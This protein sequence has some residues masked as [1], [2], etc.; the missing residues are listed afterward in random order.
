[1]EARFVDRPAFTVAGVAQSGQLGEFKY[2]EIWEKQYMPFDEQI[3]PF[4]IDGGYYG[5][6]LG[7]G[8]HLVYL[9]GMAVE[10]LQ[11]LPQGVERRVIPAA[12]YAVFDCS[13]Q[14]IGATWQMA[15]GEWLPVSSFE[16]DTGAVDFE[17]YPPYPGEGEMRVEIFIPVKEKQ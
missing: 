14:A 3:K 6:T 8:D 5:V 17:F 11:E 4:S 9:A 10:G 2:G 7:E 1:M 16:L 12:R 13:L 15:Y